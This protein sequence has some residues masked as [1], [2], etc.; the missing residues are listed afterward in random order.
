QALEHLRRAA[1]IDPLNATIRLLL[2]ELLAASGDASASA[3]EALNAKDL[4]GGDATITERA[5]RVLE[6]ATGIAAPGAAAR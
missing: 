6:R 5:R 3:E 2:A 1:E 4:A